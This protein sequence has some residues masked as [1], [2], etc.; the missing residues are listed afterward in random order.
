ML[1][2]NIQY[3]ADTEMNSG[4]LHHGCINFKQEVTSLWIQLAS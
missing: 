2:N 1:I 3:Y 4:K